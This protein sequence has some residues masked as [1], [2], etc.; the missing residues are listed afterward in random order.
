MILEA[1]SLEVGPARCRHFVDPGKQIDCLL[2]RKEA[3][4]VMHIILLRRAHKDQAI[5]PFQVYLHVP[6][7]RPPE[8]GVPTLSSSPAAASYCASSS[9]GRR[10]GTRRTGR[11]AQSCHDDA[12]PS[13]GEF[14]SVAPSA[15]L[16]PLRSIL[17][18]SSAISAAKSMA[19]AMLSPPTGSSASARQ[20]TSSKGA[21]HTRLLGGRL[22]AEDGVAKDCGAAAA[23]CLKQLRTHK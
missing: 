21:A 6:A 13:A 22:R 2:V 14:F 8:R 15:A 7:L 11:S 4:D 12:R 3:R 16:S 18:F 10:P 19:V 5:S 17:R 9:F 23:R 1:A 20:E